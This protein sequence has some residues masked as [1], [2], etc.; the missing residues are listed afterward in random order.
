MDG[1]KIDGSFVGHLVDGSKSEVVKTILGLARDLGI[2][3]VAEGVETEE[4][5]LALRNLGCEFAQG[6]LFSRPVTP[7]KAIE[8]VADILRGDHPGFKRN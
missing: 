6:Y 2:Y 5:L 4:Q 7:L 1:L 8:M 3:V